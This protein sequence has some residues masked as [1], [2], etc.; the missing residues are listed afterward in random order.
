MQR[1]EQGVSDSGITE[2]CHMVQGSIPLR[3]VILCEQ[4]TEIQS[5]YKCRRFLTVKTGLIIAVF[6]TGNDKTEMVV[7]SDGKQSGIAEIQKIF[8][9][10]IGRC[11]R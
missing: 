5:K 3:K 4:H 11:L 8:V 10:D 2:S 1:T 7:F 9:F 6:C